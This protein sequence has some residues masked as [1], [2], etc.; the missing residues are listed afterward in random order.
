MKR[1]WDRLD[2]THEVEGKALRLCLLI[3]STHHF[4][5]KSSAAVA[6]LSKQ[7]DRQPFQVSRSGALNLI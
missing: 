4:G 5:A 1:P 2:R 3:Y 6:L 7:L